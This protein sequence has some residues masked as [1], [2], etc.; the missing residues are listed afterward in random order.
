MNVISKRTESQKDINS[1]SLLI[2]D[3]LTKK[4]AKHGQNFS[5]YRTQ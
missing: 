3:P 4:Y 2:I 1:K 5:N